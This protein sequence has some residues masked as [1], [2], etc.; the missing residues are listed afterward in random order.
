MALVVHKTLFL[1]FA[2]RLKSLE[3][4]CPMAYGIVRKELNLTSENEPPQ[5]AIKTVTSCIEATEPQV[6]IQDVDL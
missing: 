4:P 2:G 3:L 6:C 5:L 1:A